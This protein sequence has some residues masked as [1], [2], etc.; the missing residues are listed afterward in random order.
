ML[1]VF[2]LLDAYAESI[3]KRFSEVL[4]IF[5]TWTLTEFKR[6]FSFFS[7]S[8]FQYPQVKYTQKFNLKVK[9]FSFLP[10][11][12][13]QPDVRV[14]SNLNQDNL[15]LCSTWRFH[16]CP[17]IS[18]EALIQS[19]CFTGMI[20]PRLHPTEVKGILSDGPSRQLL[21]PSLC[22]T[23]WCNISALQ[24]YSACTEKTMKPGSGNWA[25]LNHFLKL[26]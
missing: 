9:G 20:N 18:P 10:V 6:F 21:D 23:L 12:Q 15:N 14:T 4:K 2:L 24:S 13:I 1:L 11:L 5:L 17:S 8:N 7:P 25:L 26:W 22:T 16:C 19:H 3:S